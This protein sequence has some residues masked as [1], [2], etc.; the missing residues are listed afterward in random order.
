M[1]TKLL[2]EGPFVFVGTLGCIVSGYILATKDAGHF[3]AHYVFG[4]LAAYCIYRLIKKFKKA[5]TPSS[6]SAQ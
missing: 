4:A 5:K 6:G 3:V 2:P 1:L